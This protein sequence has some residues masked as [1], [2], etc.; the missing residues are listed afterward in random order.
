MI[1]RESEI[2]VALQAVLVGVLALYGFWGCAFVVLLI[3]LPWRP[4]LVVGGYL[5]EPIADWHFRRARE[6][7]RN[8]DGMAQIE[9]E[10][11][12]LLGTA[13]DDATN[14]HPPESPAPEAGG[15]PSESEVIVGAK[16]FRPT[17][18]TE[19]SLQEVPA[20]AQELSSTVEIPSA[21]TDHVR[22]LPQGV[23]NNMELEVEQVKF[24]DDTAEA[25]VRFHSPSVKELVIRQRYLLR[26][27]AGSWLVESRQPA[28]GGSKAPQHPIA[29]LGQPVSFA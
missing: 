29:S 26:R 6:R 8:R 23:F 1:T 22:N 28:N 7:H 4:F 27:S 21:I 13:K 12:A 3:L 10:L 5:A 14:P 19:V 18:G 11:D 15:K 9:K 17:I 25:Y 2:R 16:P 20:T 24:K